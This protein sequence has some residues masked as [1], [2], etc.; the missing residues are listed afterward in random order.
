MHQHP[1]KTNLAMTR[2]TALE[3]D[4]TNFNLKREVQLNNNNDTFR[5]LRTIM[6]YNFIVKFVRNSL[7]CYRFESIQNYLF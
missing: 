5:V 3:I 4:E 2:K 1:R 6:K 7:E